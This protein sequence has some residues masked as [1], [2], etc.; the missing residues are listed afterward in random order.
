MVGELAGASRTSFRPSQLAEALL[1]YTAPAAQEKRRRMMVRLGG[2][3]GC[4]RD[5]IENQLEH[6]DSML[7]SHLSECRGDYVKAVGPCA[8]AGTHMLERSLGGGSGSPGVG[9]PG[10]GRKACLVLPLGDRRAARL[11]A[12]NSVSSHLEL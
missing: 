6:L 3:L 12:V 7:L 5:N 2:R 10:L 9:V 8:Y 11:P 4:Q 1:H